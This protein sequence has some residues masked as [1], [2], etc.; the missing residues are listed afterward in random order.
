MRPVS[1]TPSPVEK[2]VSLSL[3][4]T[5]ACN[6]RCR[7][8]YQNRLRHRV[9]T[10]GTLRSAMDWALSVRRPGLEIAFTGG[11][12]LLVF[13]L[14]RR[15]VTYVA[16]RSGRGR[17]PRYLL[18][19][20]GL[21]L[22]EGTIDFLAAHRFD[23]QLSFD[24]VPAAQDVR[25]EGSF[26]ILDALL[27]R[28]RTRHARFYRRHVSVALTLVP[29]RIDR[30]SESL[31]Y[32]LSKQVPEVA[33]SPAL[34]P[35][36][37][38][39][40]PRIEELEVQFRRLRRISLAHFN[41]SGEIPLLLFRGAPEA[42]RDGRA[43]R[44]MCG[45]LNGRMPAVHPDGE[46]YGCIMLGGPVL[47]AKNP[48]L[49][50]ELKRLRIGRLDDPKL[51]EHLEAFAHE[52]RS[53]EF[54]TDKKGKYSSYGRCRECAAFTSC[55]ICPVSIGLQPRSTDPRR[56]PD[57]SCAFT[58]VAFRARRSFIR[59]TRARSAPTRT[60]NGRSSLDP[61]RH[62][63]RPSA[64]EDAKRRIEAFVEA[65]SPLDEMSL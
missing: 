34:A 28:L 18:L 25:A 58:Q 61:R 35:S 5:T 29:E 40:L 30:L 50:S 43:R 41:K 23:V 51:P 32:F 49:A 46:V 19:T 42:S 64:L 38:W 3:L 16:K 1:D 63:P 4:L 26:P 21:L 65:A 62:S 56:V 9:M 47:A 11:E 7:Y 24:G 55:S 60:G 20:N 33:I 8:C 37:T 15:A 12:P 6:L 2:I 13:P 31:A 53:S 14:V 54:L 59:E 52:A 17:S 57:F 45:V 48:W 39:A 10:W 27:D 22:N 36:C 44:S